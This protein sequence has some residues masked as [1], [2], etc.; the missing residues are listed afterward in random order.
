MGSVN[1]TTA[2]E[3]DVIQQCATSKGTISIRGL[4]TTFIHIE[5]LQSISPDHPGLPFALEVAHNWQ[6]T[7]I[8]FSDLREIKGLL[9]AYDNTALKE[10]SFPLLEQISFGG[11]IIT[12]NERVPIMS[13]GIPAA[14]TSSVATAATTNFIVEMNR[15]MNVHGNISIANV[16]SIRMGNLTQVEGDFNVNQSLLTLLTLPSLDKVT[17]LS[18]QNNPAL[19]SIRLKTLETLSGNLYLENNPLFLG[20][21]PEDTPRFKHVHGSIVIEQTEEPSHLRSLDFGNQFKVVE[22]SF[23][24]RAK[25]A[26][27][28]NR[29]VSCAALKAQFKQ[30]G[31]VRGKFSCL[32]QD[33]EGRTLD[34]S[35]SEE[36]RAVKI[37]A[38]IGSILL[39]LVLIALT[40]A[41]S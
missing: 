13:S 36:S 20:F 4:T 25:L 27:A 28:S 7:R 32:L 29:T 3:A 39:N 2:S 41:A 35:G 31:I 26:E 16:A 18:I 30:S 38:T 37:Q 19:Q 1:V 12:A 40:R 24:L 33:S 21:V 14:D 9:G 6:A 17:T 8:E 22:G 23:V 34:T 11:M 15:L 10:L 5:N